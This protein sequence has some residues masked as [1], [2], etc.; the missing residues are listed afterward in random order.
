MRA[1]SLASDG[2]RGHLFV[3]DEANFSVQMFSADGVYLGCFDKGGRA[4]CRKAVNDTVVR[5]ILF[6]GRAP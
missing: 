4:E 1:C 3:C 2:D 6:S 5:R